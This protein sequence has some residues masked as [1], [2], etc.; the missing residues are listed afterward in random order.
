[1]TAVSDPM[2]QPPKGKPITGRTVLIWLVGFFSVIFVANAILIQLAL[3]SFPGLTSDSAYEDGLAYNSKLAA[4]R[5]QEMLGWSIA[6]E[7]GRIEGTADAMISVS[8]R[9]ANEAP[10]A[11]LLVTARL[12]RVASPEEPRT[13]VLREGEVGRYTVDVSGLES[14]NWLLEL[15]A[16]RGDGDARQEFRSR[17]RVFL[18]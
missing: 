3:D 18:R 14:G 2:S 5:D 12:Q 15:V 13:L 16:A 8:A 4:A 9:N 6:G 10:I 1:M 11:G 7:V 17:N